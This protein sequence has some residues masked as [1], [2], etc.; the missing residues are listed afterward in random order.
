MI[1][2]QNIEN[3]SVQG[4]NTLTYKDKT[5]GGKDVTETSDDITI[6]K[7]T[8]RAYKS[9]PG[10]VVV[11]DN[12]KPIFTVDKQG[13]EDIVVWNPYDTASKMSDFG[14]ADG[15]KQMSEFC[16]LSLLI[17]LMLT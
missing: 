8:D 9:V 16:P 14:P 4:L 17:G 13:L 7:E 6:S 15:Y 5:Q 2:V 10:S 12:G 11:K 3:I 1:I